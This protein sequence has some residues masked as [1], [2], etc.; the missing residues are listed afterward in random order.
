MPKT[1]PG[2]MEAHIVPSRVPRVYDRVQ[3]GPIGMPMEEFCAL[4]EMALTTTPMTN[5]DPR[6]ALLERIDVRMCS[7][8][9]D[10]AILIRLRHP[11]QD[12]RTALTPAP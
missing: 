8:R 3:M 10:G 9:D 12:V 7:P 5:D 1:N 4:V 11:P 6:V 2:G